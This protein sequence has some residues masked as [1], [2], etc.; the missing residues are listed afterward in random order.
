M[1]EKKFI[2]FFK[3]QFCNVVD[4]GTSFQAFFK[5]FAYFLVMKGYIACFFLIC[6][7]FVYHGRKET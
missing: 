6:T 5:D 4:K 1:C 2:F 7:I 3:L